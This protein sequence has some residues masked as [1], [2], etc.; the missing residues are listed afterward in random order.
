MRTILSAKRK[1]L[2]QAILITQCEKYPRCPI[3][4][5]FQQNHYISAIYIYKYLSQT[6]VSRNTIF[7]LVKLSEVKLLFF[8]KACSTNCPFTSCDISSP[9]HLRR[10]LLA[11]IDF[12]QIYFC[13]LSSLTPKPNL[14]E[15]YFFLI[16]QYYFSFFFFFTLKTLD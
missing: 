7:Y 11:K 5:M 1:W 12:N 6:S 14:R 9:I 10:L 13:S 2:H 16:V 4:P 3:F 15:F 8:Q